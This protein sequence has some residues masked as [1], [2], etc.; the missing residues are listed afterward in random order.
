MVTW[1]EPVKNAEYLSLPEKNNFVSWFSGPWCSVHE[2]VLTALYS[3]VN[4]FG[5]QLG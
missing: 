2:L 3:A 1:F 4:E 5:G